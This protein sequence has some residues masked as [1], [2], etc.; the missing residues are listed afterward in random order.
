MSHVG[1]SWKFWGRVVEILSG[2]RLLNTHPN[3]GGL[4]LVRALLSTVVMYSI[5]LLAL[6][7]LDS[8]RPVNVLVVDTI[9]WAGAIFAAVYASL[10]ARFASQWAYLAN[11]YNEIKQTEIR[12]ASDNSG[13][14][15]SA[16]KLAQWKAA[17][18]EDAENLH[19]ARKPIYAVV[20]K[21]W[22]IE[23]H[24]R[25]EYADTASGC[26]SGDFDDLLALVN[27]SCDE[28]TALRGTP[29][30][31]P[32]EDILTLAALIL[33]LA[34]IFA[35]LRKFDS[36][37]QSGA[38]IAVSGILTAFLA[39]SMSTRREILHLQQRSL[40]E[41]K[42]AQTQGDNDASHEKPAKVEPTGNLP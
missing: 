35:L 39:R 13:Q 33:M 40:I 31:S 11:L 5:V 37:W 8:K 12:L 9:P 16:K 38:L 23:K 36:D 1:S 4:I 6:W 27:Q 3:G 18:I 30:P 28:A 17:F 2:E 22:A 7:F 32:T 24:V 20:I 41:P 10:Y 14:E 26:S 15:K 19:L 29:R 34:G 42:I 25:E 21:N